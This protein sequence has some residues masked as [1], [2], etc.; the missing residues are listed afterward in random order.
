MPLSSFQS[1]LLRLLASNRQ[2]ESYVAGATP[3]NRDASRYSGDVD[4][5]RPA[6]RTGR[7]LVAAEPLILTPF[8]V[9]FFCIFFNDLQFCFF[10]GRFGNG[11]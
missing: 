3:L 7:S 10:P 11:V 4:F 6:R 2:P 9:Q 1:E 5:W 8:K